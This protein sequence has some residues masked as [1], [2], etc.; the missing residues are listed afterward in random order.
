MLTVK[1]NLFHHIILLILLSAAAAETKIQMES[2]EELKAL[3]VK[4]VGDV[5]F[6]RGYD[7]KAVRFGAGG[8]LELPTAGVFDPKNGRIEFRVRPLWS[9]NDGKRHSFFHLGSGHTHVT[10]FK[11]EFGAL[12]FV[13]KRDKAHYSAV[14]LPIG[15]WQ[16]GEWHRIAAEW[17]PLAR[18]VLLLLQVDDR[19]KFGIGTEPLESVPE[20]IYIG[21]RGEGREPAAADMDSLIISKKPQTE[22][23][24]S[25][26]DAEVSARI[27]CAEPRGDLRRV[28]DFT[29]IWNS[30]SVPLPFRKGDAYWRRFKEA[31]FR[32]ARIVA[33]SDTW[34][35]GIA[36]ERDEKGKLKLDFSDFDALVDT[37]RSA[38]AELYVRL[39]Y[40]MPRLLSSASEGRGWAYAPPKDYA[41]WDYLM[42]EIVQHCVRRKLGVEYFVTSLNE[43]DI[44]VRRGLADWRTICELYER[45]SKIVKEIDPSAKV[46]GP[47]LAADVHGEGERFMREFLRFCRERKAPLDFVCFHAYRRFHPCAYENLTLLV[48]KFVREEY[49]ESKPEYFIDEFNLWL[50]DAKQ[51]NEYGAAYIAASLHFMRRAGLTK[52]S[53]VSFNHFLPWSNKETIIVR[54]KGQF[55]KTRKQPARFLRTQFP[56]A[57]E[58][59]RCIL[60]HP[61]QRGFFTFGRYR[62]KVSAGNPALVF[63]TGLAIKPFP[64][65]DGVVFRVVVR[66]AGKSKTIFEH[67]QR[68][69][70]W[71][72]HEIPLSEFAGKDVAI[73]FRTECGANTIADWGVWGEPRIIAADGRTSFDFIDT[74]DDAETGVASPPWKYDEATIARYTGLP[75][76]KGPVV[77]APYFVFKMYSMLGRRELAVQLN[78]RDG[79]LDDNSAGI[80]ASKDSGRVTVLLWRFDLCSDKP[81][82]FRLRFERLN[83]AFPRVGSWRMRRYLIDSTH[84]NPYYDYVIKGKPNNNGNYNLETGDL[85]MVEERTVASGAKG[86]LELKVTLEP[87]AVSLIELAPEERGER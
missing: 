83:Q 54:H 52:C 43:G 27:D 69:I 49:P 81:R 68:E 21:C 67:H 72:R 9:G 2:A 22:L 4:V 37:L 42:R 47:A 14:D 19:W 17:R 50:K 44:S 13:Y 18:E 58:R 79:I 33:F 7:G 29:T 12:R 61:P 39:A 56:V 30:R 34:L 63:Y 20:T 53:I 15:Q 57:G 60:A 85:D 74:I 36:I 65:M 59:K 6:V 3:G 32:L 24:F 38:G 16:K 23:P 45:T 80:V 48:K 70:R 62:L 41:E 55:N 84:T 78:G 31:D 87:K 40:N 1:T 86:A 76:I 28:H 11:T 66:A 77:T 25:G 46:G 5:S 82:T 35:W 10:I 26:G 73:E 75:L 8:W 64:R 71:T 51:D